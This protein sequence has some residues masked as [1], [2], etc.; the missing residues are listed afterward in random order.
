MQLNIK[1]ETIEKINGWLRVGVW[2]SF[3]MRHLR[4]KHTPHENL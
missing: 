4:R 3:R 1:P 2:T